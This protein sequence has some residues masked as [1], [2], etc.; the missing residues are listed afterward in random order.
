VGTAFPC[1]VRASVVTGRDLRNARPSLDENNLPAVGFSLNGDGARKFGAATEAN[2]GRQLAI[3][4]DGRVY[5]APVIQ[6]RISDEGRISGSFTQQEAQD[7]S[8]TLRSGALPASLTYLEERTVG[9]TLGAD[10][11]RAGVAASIGGLAM[12]VI[13]MVFYY[14]LTGLN[15]II[16]IL[17]GLGITAIWAR[18]P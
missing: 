2:I 1:G 8:L 12:V 11:V 13:F 16:S 4:L 17:G 9:P 5:S 7:L 18:K 15:A 6:S 10:S 14:K 3:V